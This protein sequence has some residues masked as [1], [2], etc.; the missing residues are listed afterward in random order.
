MSWGA[1]HQTTSRRGR[2]AQDVQQLHINVFGMKGAFF[3]LQAFCKELR[4]QHVHLMIDNTTAVA[5]INNMGGSH[6]APCNALAREI[7]FGVL[8]GIYELVLLTC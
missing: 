7:W 5:Y 1:V 3:A 2:C 4:G 6:S 8:K